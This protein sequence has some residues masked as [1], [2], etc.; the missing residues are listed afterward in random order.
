M[1]GRADLSPGSV[2]RLVG[3]RAHLCEGDLGAVGEEDRH[4]AEEICGHLRLD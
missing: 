2:Y 3:R 1:N 4:Q